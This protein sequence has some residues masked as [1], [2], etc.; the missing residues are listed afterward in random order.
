M[1]H[2]ILFS[3]ILLC[4]SLNAQTS[5]IASKSANIE[6]NNITSTLHNFGEI[7]P[8]TIIDSVKY[9]GPNSVIQYSHMDHYNR[10]INR[11]MIDTIQDDLLFLEHGYSI[12]FLKN[13]YPPNTKFIDFP[14]QNLHNRPIK[15]NN[16]LWIFGTLILGLFLI[17]KIKEIRRA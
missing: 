6:S 1:K 16:N 4:S 3:L 13:Y 7:G 9:L 2:F 12:Q 17:F 8:M 11:I 10:I 5:I 15:S 14:S